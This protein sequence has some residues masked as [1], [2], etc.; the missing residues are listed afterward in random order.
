MWISETKSVSKEFFEFTDNQ[1][2]DARNKSESFYWNL[3]QQ[4]QRKNEILMDGNSIH[5][6]M[7]NRFK[8]YTSRFYS[9]IWKLRYVGFFMLQ[10]KQGLFISNPPYKVEM[11]DGDFCRGNPVSSS[12]ATQR[13]GYGNRGKPIIKAHYESQSSKFSRKGSK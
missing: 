10:S 2:F 13:Y 12:S 9:I 8:L 11:F 5:L 1:V 7:I 6:R 3:P 4:V